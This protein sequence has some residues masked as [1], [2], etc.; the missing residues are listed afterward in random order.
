MEKEQRISDLK[1]LLFLSDFKIIKCVE[2]QLTG[3]PWP[4]DYEALIKQ[5]KEWRKELNLL[6]QEIV[7]EE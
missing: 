1:K 3:E 4:Y 2:A 6:Q 7:N 5:R